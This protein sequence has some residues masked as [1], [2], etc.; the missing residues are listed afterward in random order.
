LG[1]QHQRS[2]RV[3]MCSKNHSNA[4]C[5][6]ADGRIAQHCRRIIQDFSPSLPSVHA[7][8][9]GPTFLGFG[10]GIG[11]KLLYDYGLNGIPRRRDWMAM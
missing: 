2:W 8:S 1:Q 10:R 11:S 4:I 5:A 3:A 7:W 6:S 9:T